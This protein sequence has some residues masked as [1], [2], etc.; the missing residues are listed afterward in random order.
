MQHLLIAAALL[1]P[2]AGIAA[3]INGTWQGSYICNQGLTG[4]TLTVAPTK[5]GSARGVFR[6]YQVD[7]NPGVPD[8]CFAMSGTVSGNG[9]QLQ[10]EAWLYRPKHYVTVDLA[11]TLSPDGTSLAGSIF[12]PNCTTFV[13]HRVSDHTSP[14]ACSLPDVPVS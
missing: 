6:F 1:L 13:L 11:G 5:D 9:I 14:A 10:A 12:G 4:L 2:G 7:E 8:G 3:E